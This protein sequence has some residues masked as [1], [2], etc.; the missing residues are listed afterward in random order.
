[1]KNGLMPKVFSIILL[2]IFLIFSA[3]LAQ[4]WT[5][6]TWAQHCNANLTKDITVYKKV[7][8]EDGSIVLTAVDTVTAGAYVQSGDTWSD[9]DMHTLLYF[10]NGALHEYWVYPS[11]VH[12]KGNSKYVWY[13][14]G[15]VDTFPGAL[16]DDLEALRKRCAISYPSGT[17]Y[18][19]TTL[20]QG[21]PM[22]ND[23][24]PAKV[25]FVGPKPEAT[26]APATEAPVPVGTPIPGSTETVVPG[27]TTAT[28]KPG[29]TPKPNATAKPNSTTA[30][31]H[32][33]APTR[34]PTAEDYT[35]KQLGTVT[36]LVAWQ[37]KSFEI[38]TTELFTASTVPPEQQL[39]IIYAPKEGSAALRRS[40]ST[41]AYLTRHC[42]AGYLVKVLEY[43]KKFC[44]VIY[45]GDT[46]YVLTSSL[47][48]ITPGTEPDARALISVNGR[49]NGATY[50]NV[51]CAPD[52]NSAK[53]A[54]WDTGTEVLIYGEQNGWY[55]IEARGRRGW[56][57]E[58][59][60][61]VTE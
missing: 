5:E 48:F 37:G 50:V 56:V 45:D 3:A 34:V 42:K 6:K 13:T 41:S 28:I 1:M 43:G 16:T 52:K 47:R 55:Q 27:V 53:V 26:Q 10:K 21:F 18:A 38:A 4:E 46:G 8:A 54:E 58:K 51:R 30:V 61:T 11:D 9:P 36:S 20:D 17:I 25:K 59:F 23:Y 57:L 24:D 39:A 22:Y 60:L 44:K 35:L 2:I 33:A 12:V 31:K 40:A 29:S 7:T 14:D 15:C 32:T 49:T 19:I